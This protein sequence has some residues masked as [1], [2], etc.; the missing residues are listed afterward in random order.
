[1]IGSDTAGVRR[2]RDGGSE[3]S[4]AGGES[5]GWVIESDES[6]PIEERQRQRDTVSDEASY[7]GE[8][9]HDVAPRRCPSVCTDD[10]PSFES[11]RHD[12]RLRR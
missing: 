5:V 11:D 10:D 8:V 12:G 2:T 4:S 6:S 9:T 7:P 1:M 3:I